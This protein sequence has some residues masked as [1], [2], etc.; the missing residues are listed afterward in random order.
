MSVTYTEDCCFN[1]VRD[2]CKGDGCPC[3]CHQPRSVMRTKHPSDPH[4]LAWVGSGD[5]VDKLC[6]HTVQAAFREGW[7]AA[8]AFEPAAENERLR[9]A[10][11][12]IA[13]GTWTAKNS[14][15]S[16]VWTARQALKDS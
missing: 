2:H 1:Y 13:R 5:G 16:I 3:G 10:L 15:E 12:L 4:F 6:T 9:E 7:N 11:I 14:V 8:R